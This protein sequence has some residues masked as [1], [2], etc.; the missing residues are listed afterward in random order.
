[1]VS[2]S[3]RGAC[4]RDELEGADVT[5]TPEMVKRI[6]R[7]LAFVAGA[8]ICGPGMHVASREL[9]WKPD[10]VQMDEYAEKHWPEHVTAAQFV[11]GVIREPTLFMLD[12]AD[13]IV[14]RETA[15]EIWQTM[16]TAAVEEASK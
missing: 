6:A 2:L 9:G 5:S 16:L 15:K 13:A 7:A 3:R 11:L 4:G 10:N 12:T 8:K 1:M 14:P